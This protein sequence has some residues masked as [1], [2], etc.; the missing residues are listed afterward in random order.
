MKDHAGPVFHT[1]YS[2][3]GLALGDFDNDGDLDAV[4][5]CLNDKP[6]LLQ[7]N[8][9]QKM[10]WIGL[11]LKGVRSNRDGIGAKVVIQQGNRRLVRWLAGGSSF[12][13]SHDKRIVFG[14]GGM[15][16]VDMINCEITWPS[17]YVQSVPGLKPNQ[18]HTV[19]ERL[20]TTP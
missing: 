17:G 14:L 10:P 11:K 20:V 6:L 3:R 9:G 2:G 7:N 13:A 4:F 5:V 18:Y 15:P 8:S 12:L 19:Q 1:R 16:P